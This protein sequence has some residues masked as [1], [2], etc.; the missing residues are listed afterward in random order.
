MG[1]GHGL[2]GLP[3]GPLPLLPPPHPLQ[4]PFRHS[5]FGRRHGEPCTSRRPRAYET[6]MFDRECNPWATSG[7][8]EPRMWPVAMRGAR[9]CAAPGH[10]SRPHPLP[11]SP[12]LL[13]IY[14]LSIFLSYCRSYCRTECYATSAVSRLQE[15]RVKLSSNREPADFACHSAR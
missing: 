7:R 5:V 2:R 8:Q 13:S 11:S 4:P 10:P 9:F 15:K 1:L 12:I 14:C 6:Q 3:A